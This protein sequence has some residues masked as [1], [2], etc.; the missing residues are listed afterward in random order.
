MQRHVSCECKF[1]GK[2]C[3]SN[4]TFKCWRKCKKHHICEQDYTWNPA[5]CSC[6]NIKYLESIIDNSV[7]TCGEIIEE[8]TKINPK[9]FNGQK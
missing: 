2:T 9:R 1:Y 6:K 5:T 4:Q 3:D 8:E 7:I